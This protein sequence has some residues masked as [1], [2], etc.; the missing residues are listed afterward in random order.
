MNA[1]ANTQE[2]LFIDIDKTA[3]IYK[4]IYSLSISSDNIISSTEK[5]FKTVTGGDIK[6]TRLIFS[7][8][9]AKIDYI[10][11]S[12]INN[13]V[14][15]YLKRTYETKAK[16]VENPKFPRYTEIHYSDF[17][18]ALAQETIDR[19]EFI[20]NSDIIA[21]T[22]VV[23]KEH[24]FYEINASEKYAKILYDDYF[25]NEVKISL[26]YFDKHSI[27]LDVNGIEYKAKGISY[28]TCI[29]DIL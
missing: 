9:K 10:K 25:N 11:S 18:I 14:R 26:D 17:E 12:I 27:Y 15:E 21:V 16:L 29:K 2:E 19:L 7:P 8:D 28:N 6:I 22:S 5:L 13:H 4:Q 3:K 1:Q 24:I 23:T 20:L